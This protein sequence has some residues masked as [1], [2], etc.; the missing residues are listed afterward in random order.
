MSNSRPL[1]TRLSQ[2]ELWVPECHPRVELKLMRLAMLVLLVLSAAGVQAQAMQEAKACQHGKGLDEH[3]KYDTFSVFE[4]SIGPA[5]YRVEATGL[6]IREIGS[7]PVQSFGLKLE[8]E[9][10]TGVCVRSE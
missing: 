6:G 4:F 1:G 9:Y 3:P 5:R 10:I 8:G 2:S 7:Q